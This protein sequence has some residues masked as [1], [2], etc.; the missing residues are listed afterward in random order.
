MKRQ[1]ELLTAVLA[2][3]KLSG[4]AKAVYS[5]MFMIF[6]Q[7]KGINAIDMAKR[8]NS[9]PEAVDAAMTELE[10]YELITKRAHLVKK[11]SK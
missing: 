5:Q 11:K 1:L 2:S 3:P 8:W 6:P 4:M 9:T 7:G 10:S